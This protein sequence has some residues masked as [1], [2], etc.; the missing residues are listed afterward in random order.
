M[1]F[2]EKIWTICPLLG[3]LFL[4]RHPSLKWTDGNNQVFEIKKQK[5]LF[6]GLSETWYLPV[7][8]IKWYHVPYLQKDVVREVVP[9]FCK[10][11]IYLYQSTLGTM[12]SI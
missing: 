12:L 7:L 1:S 8:M 3:F 9:T 4:S 2:L 11:Y 5:E 6:G 10:K